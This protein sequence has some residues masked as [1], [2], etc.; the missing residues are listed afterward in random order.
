MEFNEYTNAP[1]ATAPKNKPRKSSGAAKSIVTVLLCVLLGGGAGF[2]GGYYAKGGSRTIILQQT[3][4][5]TPK[6]TEQTVFDGTVFTQSQAGSDDPLT[7]AE[8]AA[9]V[10][11]AVV[12][13]TTETVTTDSRL[14]QYVSKGA[15]SGVIFR[16]DG[17]I[18]TNNHVIDSAGKITVTLH[19]GA[20]YEA[21]VI[22]TDEQTDLAVLKIDAENLDIAQ[23]GDSSSLIVGQTAVAVGNPL[24]T[25]G[26]TVTNG[27]I[28]ALDREITIDSETMKQRRRTL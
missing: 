9:K 6:S 17:Y 2:L 25:L 23:F 28:S 11:S 12:E 14:K 18:V 27:I 10:Q 5:P 1:E 4:T 26:G 15:G 19:N 24:G 22:G 13:V 21:S 20:S 16:Q 8:I 7:I 3:Q